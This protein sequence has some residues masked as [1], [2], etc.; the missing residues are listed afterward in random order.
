MIKNLPSSNRNTTIP[1]HQM[2]TDHG[3]SEWSKYFSHHDH[4]IN[5]SHQVVLSHMERQSLCRRNTKVCAKFTYGLTSIPLLYITLSILSS[6]DFDSGGPD[7]GSVIIFEF[8]LAAGITSF[9]NVC[10]IVTYTFLQMIDQSII[11]HYH[12]KAND[13]NAHVVG[14]DS[15][16]TFMVFI[17]AFLNCTRGFVLSMNLSGQVEEDVIAVTFEQ[18]HRF[19]WITFILQSFIFL[20]GLSF[21]VTT[22]SQSFNRH[23]NTLDF[24][25]TDT[26]GTSKPGSCCGGSISV[27]GSR[28]GCRPC[29]CVGCFGGPRTCSCAISQICE[30]GLLCFI[31]CCCKTKYRQ[32]RSGR[33]ALKVDHKQMLQNKDAL[34]QRPGWRNNPKLTIKIRDL[35]VLCKE[36]KDEIDQRKFNI[37]LKEEEMLGTFQ[38]CN[39]LED[40]KMANQWLMD[41]Y[42]EWQEVTPKKKRSWVARIRKLRKK[43]NVG[44]I[45]VLTGRMPMLLKRRKIIMEQALKTKRKYECVHAWSL[46]EEYLAE[47]IT[48]AVR[49]R[50]RVE[51]GIGAASASAQGASELTEIQIARNVKNLN[52]KKKH[53]IRCQMALKEHQSMVDVETGLPM[54]IAFVQ[55]QTRM[56]VEKVAQHD[57]LVRINLALHAASHKINELRACVVFAYRRRLR[58]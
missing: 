14:D 37:N 53:L 7:A 32:T 40:R 3:T 34:T 48:L 10:L 25:G 17:A 28:S 51:H 38:Y 23:I 18:F 58:Q 19:V 22:S 15:I 49:A 2:P 4:E 26:N 55:I 33:R 54:S 44:G 29:Y 47:Q 42:P 45:S 9:V 20:C 16:R 12:G 5:P 50:S 36:M 35:T 56:Q 30:T 52:E 13:P 21:V 43:V 41:Q 1:I 46:E 57:K 39:N 6:T 27:D 31:P 24:G 8:I 11:N